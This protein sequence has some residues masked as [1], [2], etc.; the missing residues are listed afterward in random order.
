MVGLAKARPNYKH[1]TVLSVQATVQLHEY[2]QYYL[3]ICTGMSLKVGYSRRV[4][5]TCMTSQ[6][7]LID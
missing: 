6:V 1:N 4:C 5:D 2:R 3:R 7:Y